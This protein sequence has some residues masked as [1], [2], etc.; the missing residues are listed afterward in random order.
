[1]G[2]GFA[3]R[4]GR[5]FPWARGEP[6]RSRAPSWLSHLIGLLHRESPLLR[7][8]P[9]RTE[10]VTLIEAIEIKLVIAFIVELKLV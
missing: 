4:R 7:S 8:N 3:L 6:T 1:M 5:F 9:L 2:W 10:G